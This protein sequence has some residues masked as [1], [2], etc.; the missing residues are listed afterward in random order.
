MLLAAGF[1]TGI[2]RRRGLTAVCSSSN[3]VKWEVRNPFYA[4]GLYI[5]HECPDLFRIGDWWYLVF[6]EYSDLVATRYR[7]S[8]SL[9]G[10]WLT[11]NQDTFDGHAFYAAKMASDGKNRYIFG[12]NPTRSE[13]KDSGNWNWGGCHIIFQ[14][15]FFQI[16]RVGIGAW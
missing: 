2:P 15:Y 12:W 11:P 9:Q 16:F 4:P 10:P 6:S 5:T 8:R 14:T 1:N 7:M 13:N 3:L